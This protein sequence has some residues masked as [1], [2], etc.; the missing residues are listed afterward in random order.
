MRNKINLYDT[1]AA[2][3]TAPG[4]GGIGIV[5][6]S[7]K[8]ALGIADR[9]FKGQNGTP[10]SKFAALTMHYG[11]IV[12]RKAKNKAKP[13]IID[14]VMITVMRAPKS[15]TK[16]DML[17]IN[18]HGGI[19][20]LRKILELAVNSG[21][22]LAQPGEF[23]QRA[24][25]NGRIDLIQAEA[26]LNLVNAKTE[27]A[28]YPAVNQLKG[29]LSGYI[30]TLKER[31]I[32]TVAPLEAEIDF[33]QESIDKTSRRKLSVNLKSIAADIKRLLD[34]ADK[35]IMLQQG[36]S[37]VLSGA[38]N[39]GK[40]SIMNALVEYERVI[41]THV[42]GTTRD[43]VEELINV[44]GL[45]VR[46]ADTAG[47]MNSSCLITKES[48]TRSLG[49]LEKADLVLFVLDASR[50]ISK[51]DIELAKRLKNKKVIIVVN[52][53]D[54]KRKVDVSK[55]IRILPGR[56]LVEISAF[57]KQGIAK[58]GKKITAV[59]FNGHIFPND[60]MLISNLRQKETLYKS[61]GFIKNAV[62]IIA[63]K[64]YDECVVFEIKQALEALGEVLGESVD[65]DIIS[66]IFSRFCI[67]K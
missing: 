41:V 56:P 3:S 23:T 43:I 17:E 9:I 42:C 51:T 7:G 52:K 30:N 33:P 22:R 50:K 11:H 21:A 24:F 48:I 27:T 1:I 47:I 32:N 66:N 4:I 67:G 40:S 44:D 16:E 39:V 57:K 58:L 10:P 6:I 28:L 8:K 19:V 46:L 31:L 37:V 49:F 18:C 62:K 13:R 34:G 12:D 15:Y 36:I 61:Y 60:G 38:A 54:L 26:V 55:I 14:E 59:F 25:L 20:P 65:E 2:I 29:K 5:R 63:E 64:G 35:G 53:T 45:P